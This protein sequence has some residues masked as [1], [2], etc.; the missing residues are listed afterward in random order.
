MDPMNLPTMPPMATSGRTAQAES[1]P[2]GPV[3]LVAPAAPVPTAREETG[4]IGTEKSGAAARPAATG[5][6]DEDEIRS[7]DQLLSR[8]KQLGKQGGILRLAARAD[9]ELPT[10]AIEGTGRYQFVAMPGVS[11]PRLRLRLPEMPLASPSDWI[12]MLNLRSGS[13]LLQGLDISIADHGDASCRSS[14]CSW[15]AARHRADGRR[16]YLYRGDSASVRLG[17]RCPT[18][19]RNRAMRPA[20]TAARGAVIQIRNCFL[21]SGGDG[22]SVAAGRELNLE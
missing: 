14:G 8:L 5:L 12:V 15:P 16:L 7:S 18:G 2:T 19:D 20:G 10:V 21:R 4:K 3:S 22:V 6:P 9:I 1:D 11:R 17:V 13:L